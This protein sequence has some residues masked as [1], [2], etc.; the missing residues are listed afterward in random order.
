[1]NLKAEIT[2][3]TPVYQRIRS[4]IA[5]N[6]VNGRMEWKILPST[7]KYSYENI[8]KKLLEYIKYFFFFFFFYL[9]KCIIQRGSTV[10]RNRIGQRRTVQ[11][12][13]RSRLCKWKWL[14][15]SLQQPILDNQWNSLFTLFKIFSLLRIRDFLLWLYLTKYEREIFN[16]WLF[17]SA[18]KL[19]EI[20]NKKLLFYHKNFFNVSCFDSY[21]LFLFFW[22]IY[23]VWFGRKN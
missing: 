11:C 13:R 14:V 19:W 4:T 12:D 16:I 1:M 10:S 21:S 18:I 3:F 7:I 6:L 9:S 15:R 23:K 17:D 2:L 22:T 8:E 20:Q 5:N